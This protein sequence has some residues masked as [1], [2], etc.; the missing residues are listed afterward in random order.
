MRL[1]TRIALLT[2]AA[3]CA[4]TA[5]ASPVQAA[6]DTH[7]EGEL[8]S[9][10]AYL[11]DV[12]ADW[13]GTVL[14]YSHGYRPAGAPG[15]PA[16]NAP[17]T[18]TL[19]RLLAAGYALIGS[20]YATQGWAVTD[21]VPDQLATLD[22]FTERFGAA[23]RTLAWGTSYG[24]L[25]TTML[26]ERHADRFDGSLSMCGL[27]QGGAANWNSTLDPVFALKTLLAPAA[28]IPLAGF[29]DQAAARRAAS[30]LAAKTAAA[31]ETAQGRARIALAAAL[32][33][34]PGHNDP[35]QTEP[36][37][38]DWQ[39]QQANQY[40]ALTGLIQLPA[41]SWR[42]EAES[43]A[44]GNMSWNT[45]VDYTAMLGRSPLYKEVSELYREAGLSL[46]TDLAALN[47]APRIP[48]D[49]PAVRW[50]RHTSVFSG[51]LTDP[52]LNIHTTGDALIP[53]Q[54]ESA[55][56][57][58]AAAAGSGPL[59]SQA[60]VDAPGHCTFTSGEMIGALHTLEHR[61]DTGRWD[62]S[63][64]A[65]NSRARREDPAAAARYLH[66]RP[67]LYPRPHDLAHPAGVRTPSGD[68][69]P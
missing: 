49:A 67:T 69:R 55:Y 18:D 53:V 63:P 13:N 14:L 8:P 21:A 61:L 38:T 10:A 54:A 56:R 24:G 3:V 22:L 36:G 35:T 66:Y 12:P 34:I 62:A 59:L 28:V 15:N 30:A 26:A 6:T 1:R 60:Y 43:R 4:T 27:V 68:A 31:Q 42:Q 25:V 45:G 58:A 65:L 32:H 19:T 48:A 57:R 51:R 23:R 52:Q 47:R 7:L 11:M 37:P 44:G 5:V 16:Q 41:F 17:S 20:S 33:N 64:E 2:V 40:A 39:A 50:M 9:G 29:A 46:R